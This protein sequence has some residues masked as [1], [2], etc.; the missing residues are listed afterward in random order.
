M[1]TSLPTSSGGLVPR[2]SA[3]LSTAMSNLGVPV[4]ETASYDGESR[5]W[6]DR[7]NP[8]SP[9]R[10]AA[11]VALH[12]LLLKAARFEVN[13]RVAA[14]PHLRGGDYDDLAHQSADDAVVAILAKIGD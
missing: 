9:D 7:L 14:F 12:A 6:I 3:F 13:R 5:Q 11:I 10:P 4:I 8:Q 1:L 2:T